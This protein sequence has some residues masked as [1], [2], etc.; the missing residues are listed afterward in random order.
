MARAIKPHETAQ[1][2]IRPYQAGDRAGFEALV[3]TVLTEFGFHVDPVLERDLA[4]PMAS[5]GAVWV[6]V[7]GE[8][9]VGSVAVRVV[10]EEAGSG[11]GP[12]AELKRMYLYPGHRGRGLGRQ[13]LDRAVGWARGAGCRA[14]VLDTSAEMDAA[15][16]LYESVGFV[17]TGTRTETG[18]VDS[19]CEV[20]YRLDLA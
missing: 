3:S 18:T 1:P 17:R 15:Q 8:R 20:L 10:K 5:Y 9:L 11:D 12:V 2:G 19:R 16:R 13:L 7:D 4:D 14:I 6:A